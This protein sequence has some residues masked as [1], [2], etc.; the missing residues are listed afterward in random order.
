MTDHEKII[1]ALADSH[2]GMATVLRLDL[3][4]LVQIAYHHDEISLSKAS[5]L[6]GLPLTAARAALDTSAL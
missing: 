1:L 5:E 6:L 4:H 2:K 3:W